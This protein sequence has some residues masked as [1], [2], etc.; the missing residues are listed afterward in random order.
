MKYNPL[1]IFFEYLQSAGYSKRKTEISITVQSTVDA[2]ISVVWD[3]WT[4]PEHVM[5][6]NHAS[7]DW[8]TTA[9]VND[10]SAGGAFSYTMAAKDGSFSFD[11]EGTYKEVVDYVRIVVLLGD[12]RNM[13]VHFAADGDETTVRETFD[14]ETENPVEMQQ[15]GWQL[16]LDN[17]KKYAEGL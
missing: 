14:A 17:F 3:A 7:D 4:N 6:W 5:K 8:H 9:A 2:P 12:G 11:F 13:E 15:M 16:I 10:L 1:P